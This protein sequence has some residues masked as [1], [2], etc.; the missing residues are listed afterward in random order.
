MRE[1]LSCSAPLRN[2]G[3]PVVLTEPSMNLP[4]SWPNL[5]PA[6]EATMKGRSA[7]RAA[8]NN[9]SNQMNPNNTAYWSSR[10]IATGGP[11]VSDGRPGAAPAEAPHVDSQPTLPT[12][13]RK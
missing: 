12:E 6:E 8:A 4:L 7:S 2:F 10:G 5:R 13:T 9:R 11:V 3:H 1:V